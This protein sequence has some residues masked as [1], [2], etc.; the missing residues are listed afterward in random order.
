MAIYEGVLSPARVAAHYDAA[1]AEHAK[2]GCGGTSDVP[3][4]P[5]PA[6]PRPR[7]RRR[8]PAAPLSPATSI[9]CDPGT[10]S[11]DPTH[12]SQQWLRGGVP[13]A[14]E[15]EW[16]YMVT[17][18]DDGKELTCE[19]VATGP[20]GESGAVTSLPVT[21][22]GRPAAPGVPVLADDG[23]DPRT[24]F[25]LEW[26]ATPAEPVPADGYIV[27][28]RDRYG[29]WHVASRRRRPSVN[30]FNQPEGTL[31]YRVLAQSGGTESDPSPESEP[32]VVDRTPPRPARLVVA[33]S[34]GLRDWYLDGASATWE[35]D[36]DPDL[37]DGTP[38]SGV[39]TTT[40]PGPVC[41]RD[42]RR[43]PGRGH[44]AR[45]RRQ[46]GGDRAHAARRRRPADGHAE[47]PARRP[48]RRDR[49]RDGRRRRRPLRARGR[50]ALAAHRRHR[51][52]RLGLRRDR[53]F[54]CDRASPAPWFPPGR[55]CPWSAPAPADRRASAG[56]STGVSGGR[57]VL[58]QQWG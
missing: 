40:L 27:Q 47:L 10:W 23:G 30:L 4:A 58:S 17:A 46:P 34:P 2:G 39:D 56:N 24:A 21:A 8:A 22:S 54:R 36:G 11:G 31:V 37:A 16:A 44:A 32:I 18:A 6:A 42:E 33:G 14:G 49:P 38:G 50:H 7:S 13:I 53:G 12:F 29:A 25:T 45:P 15:T 28:Y 20:G 55:C 3:A 51:D 5:A 52:G 19:V 43:P 48:R 41:A 26:D 57:S 35:H 9:W 1:D